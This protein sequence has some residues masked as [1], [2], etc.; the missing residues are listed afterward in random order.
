EI[1]PYP[2]PLVDF[3]TAHDENWLSNPNIREKTLRH[4]GIIVSKTGHDRGQKEMYL[5][6]PTVRRD[7]GKLVCSND[8]LNFEV[9]DWILFNVLV[10]STNKQEV[11]IG[12]KKWSEKY[13]ETGMQFDCPK[14]RKVRACMYPKDRYSALISRQA[15]Y[16]C[17]SPDLGDLFIDAQTLGA[18]DQLTQSF[19]SGKE[20]LFYVIASYHFNA[21]IFHDVVL[22]PDF[23]KRVYWRIDKI[24]AIVDERMNPEDVGDLALIPW[25]DHVDKYLEKKRNIENMSNSVPPWYIRS[26]RFLTHDMIKTWEEEA[27]RMHEHFDE[28]SCPL[29][30]VVKQDGKA[31]V[32]HPSEVF[33]RLKKI[34]KNEEDQ[35]QLIGGDGNAVKSIHS[36]KKVMSFDG[37][38]LE[39]G[40]QLPP[41][42][43]MKK[44][45][46]AAERVELVQD[47]AG[48]FMNNAAALS[49]VEIKESGTDKLWT[50]GGWKNRGEAWYSEVAR[51]RWDKN[52]H[53]VDEIPLKE[54]TPSE[55]IRCPSR[56]APSKNLLG[57][58]GKPP[59]MK[60]SQSNQSPSTTQEKTASLPS[61]PLRVP[62][63]PPSPSIPLSYNSQFSFASASKITKVNEEKKESLEY[64]SEVG[65][66][67]E[68]ELSGLR[69]KCNNLRAYVR[70]AEVEANKPPTMKGYTAPQYVRAL[71]GII[72]CMEKTIAFGSK[73]ETKDDREKINEY[74]SKIAHL[75]DQ[76]RKKIISEDG[77]VEI[78]LSME[79]DADCK[80]D[81]KD[82][83]EIQKNK[84]EGMKRRMLELEKRRMMQQR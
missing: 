27:K 69:V 57:S 49:Y 29:P 6:S 77:I 80:E 7:D 12:G 21:S 32:Q 28:K 18:R 31:E 68:E 84:L 36:W 74:H 19:M 72:D 8:F 60:S 75:E 73:K 35:T 52:L 50:T 59:K 45:K 70:E 48:L 25:R 46:I 40:S 5:Y 53:K 30:I 2:P 61:P 78:H 82:H 39:P 14:L 3:G 83:V 34:K 67:E 76:L 1:M 65:L 10:Q 37:Q 22:G 15:T 20:M 9:G 54:G 11:Y 26:T 13:L 55:M 16:R 63:S 17:W 41:V 58:L 4:I 79:D 81:L 62:E 47:S 24:D 23:E 64:V 44:Q 71:K 38:M 43:N 51:N 42:S 56:N 66:S 33:E